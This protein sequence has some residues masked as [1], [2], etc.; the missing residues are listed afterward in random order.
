MRHA[1]Y[2]RPY[3]DHARVRRVPDQMAE[4]RTGYMRPYRKTQEKTA[5][6]TSRN[7][8]ARTTARWA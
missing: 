3:V 1:P 5:R 2:V 8:Q 7:P 6:V 4:R